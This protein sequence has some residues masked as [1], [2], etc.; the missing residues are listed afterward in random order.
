MKNIKRVIALLLASV[1][2][3]SSSTNAVDAAIKECENHTLKESYRIGERA[4]N[5]DNRH[6]VYRNLYVGNE[7]L[8]SICDIEAYIQY[9][10][11]ECIYC[12]YKIESPCGYY[13]VHSLANDPDHK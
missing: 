1:L 8:Y 12:L 10:K 3:I 7:Q 4:K 9:V 5:G 13:Y 2:C 11:Y 6:L